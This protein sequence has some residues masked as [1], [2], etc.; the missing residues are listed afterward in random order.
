MFSVICQP[1]YSLFCKNKLKVLLKD[2]NIER[3]L[4]DAIQ[5]LIVF[6]WHS[7][8]PEACST[9]PTTRAEELTSALTSI[10]TTVH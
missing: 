5:Y 9:Q 3:L 7:A 10:W 6:G 1:M 2:H 8:L 4:S